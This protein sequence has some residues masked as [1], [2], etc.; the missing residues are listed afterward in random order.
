MS[1][2]DR[3]H[4][5]GV[6]AGRGSADPGVAGL[7]AVFTPFEQEFPRS[8][9][10]LELACGQG[11]ATVWLARRG[12]S[13]W[14]VD[15]S[16]VAIE[17]AR[18][19]AALAQVEERCRFEVVDLDAG[20]PPGPPLDVILCHRFRAPHLND[21]VIERLKHGGLL[22]IAVLSEVDAAPGPYRAAPGELIAAFAVLEAIGAG[23]GHGTAWLIARK[24]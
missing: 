2:E 9:T 18:E 8:G 12:L 4:W 14:G 15:A 13:A 19:R 22:A 10:A 24:P 6:Y 16:P 3:L 11:G 23:E 5:D 7:P 21:A 20:M 17:A 1:A